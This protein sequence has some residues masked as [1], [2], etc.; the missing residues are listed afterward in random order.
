MRILLVTI[1]VASCW[2][3]SDCKLEDPILSQLSRYK[4]RVKILQELLSKKCPSYNRHKRNVPKDLSIRLEV[5]KQAYED[6]LQ[7]LMSCKNHP[8]IKATPE[9]ST[10]K[11]ASQTTIESTT[12]VATMQT[13]TKSDPTEKTTTISTTQVMMESLTLPK[14][15]QMPA[16][17]QGKEITTT[18]EA[19]EATNITT[20]MYNTTQLTTTAN[21]F[22]TCQNAYNYTEP[23]RRDHN[24]SGLKP[25][26]PHSE[27][28]YACDLYESPQWFRFSGEAGTHML[29]TCPKSLSCGTMSPLWTDSGM[30][31]EVG[32][33]VMAKVFGVVE[34]NCKGF[35]WIMKIIR[36]SWDTPNDLIYFVK[37][38]KGC[39]TAFCGMM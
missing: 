5:E 1:L 26:G 8:S 3:L 6:L 32:T 31:E 34:N 18:A 21:F 14:T 36:C 25:G 12:Q 28:G 38:Y 2:Q 17:K 20:A 30:P 29:D 19:I 24:G 39:N 7:N 16:T 9:P 13:T 23:W 27:R 10:Q 33:V 35:Y 4:I 22:D 37:S 11:P 15:T